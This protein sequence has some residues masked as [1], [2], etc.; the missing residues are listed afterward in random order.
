MP[1][2]TRQI[3]AV[4][5][6]TAAIAL[7]PADAAAERRHNASAHD[8]PPFSN[9]KEIPGVTG[10][11]IAAVEA[12]RVKYKDSVLIHGISESTEAFRG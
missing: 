10:D 2:I 4:L 8:Q 5:T 12:L 9:Y 3:A 6:A 11:E 7:F 1:A